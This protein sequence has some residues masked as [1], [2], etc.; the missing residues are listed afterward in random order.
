MMRKNVLT[1]LSPTSQ[2]AHQ[3]L[4]TYRDSHTA[5]DVIVP[6]LYV[7]TPHAMHCFDPGAAKYVFAGQLDAQLD[8][9]IAD[10]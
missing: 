7:P 10:T 3:E 8:D 2:R 9:P 6:S 1:P 4:N 5:H